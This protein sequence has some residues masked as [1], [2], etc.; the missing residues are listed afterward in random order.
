MCGSVVELARRDA[1]AMEDDDQVTGVDAEGDWRSRIERE[2]EREMGLCIS[3]SDKCVGGWRSLSGGTW[4][5]RRRAT[6]RWV[7]PCK[8]MES[9]NDAQGLDGAH[10]MSY[11]NPVF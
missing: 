3:R 1:D 4:R 9:I 8:V 6:K 11:R 7:L 5:R 2:R 10:P